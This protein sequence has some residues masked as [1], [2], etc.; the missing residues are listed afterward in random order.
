VDSDGLETYYCTISDKPNTKMVHHEREHRFQA[1]SFSHA[2]EQCA[3]YVESGEYL[4]KIVKE[5]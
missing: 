1:E 2:E 3:P 4:R 5:I